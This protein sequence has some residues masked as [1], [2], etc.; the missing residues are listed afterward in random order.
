VLTGAVLRSQSHKTL[1]PRGSFGS[2]IS[3]DSVALEGVAN[4]GLITVGQQEAGGG[5]L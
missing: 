5:R 3:F 1:A 2:S 4:G